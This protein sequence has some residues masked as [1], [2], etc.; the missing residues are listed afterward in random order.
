MYHK[1]LSNSLF[2]VGI[3]SLLLSLLGFVGGFLVSASSFDSVPDWV[4]LSMYFVLGLFVLGLVATL[5][6]MI[7][8][9]KPK[10]PTTIIS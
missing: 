10:S 9:R 4:G 2:A 8:G 1:R 6:G 7:L 3:V 5:A